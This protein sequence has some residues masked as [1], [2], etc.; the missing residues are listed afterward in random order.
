MKVI[1][2]AILLA[3]SVTAASAQGYG[4]GSQSYGGGAV[5]YN[6]H[7]YEEQQAYSPPHHE[8]GYESHS[9]HQDYHPY[10]E[11]RSYDSGYSSG[12]QY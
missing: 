5:D 7:P 4:Y 3:A 12:S 1:F 10:V 11:H 2:A 8:Y 9:D 6:S